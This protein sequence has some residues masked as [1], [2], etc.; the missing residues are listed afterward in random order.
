MDDDPVPQAFSHFSWHA[1]K[2]MFLIC[3]IQGWGHVLTDPQIHTVDGKGF[4]AGNLGFEGIGAFLKWSCLNT[5]RMR[6]LRMI[7]I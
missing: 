2:G 7:R 6:R 3:D 4:G 5:H 1:S